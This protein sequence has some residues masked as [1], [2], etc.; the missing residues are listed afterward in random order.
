M[1]NAWTPAGGAS[2]VGA[3]SSGGLRGSSYKTAATLFSL[4]FCSLSLSLSRLGVLFSAS[5]FRLSRSLSAI[6]VVRCFR[7]PPL[8][9]S[10]RMSFSLCAWPVTLGRAE[11]DSRDCRTRWHRALRQTAKAGKLLFFCIRA[12]PVLFCRNLG[13][14]FSW[15]TRDRYE[16]AAN[17]R[18]VLRTFPCGVT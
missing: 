1:D 14:V 2:A 7:S 6:S 18:Q 17:L 10:A 8:V 12:I 11:V 5:D 15:K 4:L 13:L 16:F 9:R 3:P